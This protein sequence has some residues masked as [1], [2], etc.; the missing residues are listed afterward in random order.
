MNLTLT[1]RHLDITP[2]LKAHVDE[3]MKKLD[4]FNSHIIKAEIVLTKEGAK[5]V[6]EGKVHMSHTVLAAKGQGKDM[7]IAVNDVIDKLVAQLLR[8]QGK[9]HDRRRSNHTPPS[10]DGI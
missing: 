9:F 5:D 8:Q 6:A 4:H 3:K 10:S 2:Y 7:Y 1:G